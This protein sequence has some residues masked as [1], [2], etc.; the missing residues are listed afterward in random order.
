[1]FLLE[2]AAHAHGA[3]FDGRPA[4]T[5]GV[6]AGFSFYPTK[7]ITSGEGGMILTDDE[8]VRDEAGIFRDQGKAGFFGGEH[9]RMGAA[10]RMSELHAAVGLVHL[11]RLDE[12]IAVRR[13]VAAR[14]DAALPR[15]PSSID[16]A[17][18]APRVRARLLQV[19]R[20]ARARH[21]PST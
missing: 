20:V 1:M 4:G 17:G 11:R 10:W 9:V 8:R 14:Y 7:V 6:A 12:F 5:F 3:S 15:A 13:R 19:R 2:D 16:A 18:P 21:R